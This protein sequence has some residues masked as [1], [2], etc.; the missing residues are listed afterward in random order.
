MSEDD[1]DALIDDA[2]HAAAEAF[3]AKG[4]NLT[5]DELC[6]IN[7]MLSAFLVEKLAERDKARKPHVPVE[8]S[9]AYFGGDFHAVGDFAYVPMELIERHGGNVGAA[10]HEHTGHDCRHMIHYTLDEI[11]DE[12]GDPIDDEITGEQRREQELHALYER[13]IARDGR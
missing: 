6:E 8:Y 7:D 9:L 4:I 10:F 12:N 2:T 3:S 5:F 11:C 13:Q 1:R